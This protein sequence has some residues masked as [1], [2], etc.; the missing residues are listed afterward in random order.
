MPISEMNSNIFFNAQHSPIGA[1]ASFTLGSKGA[2]GGLGLELGKPADQ[3]VF[4]GIADEN[5]IRPT[6]CGWKCHPGKATRL[7]PSSKFASRPPRQ[8]SPPSRFDTPFRS[9]PKIVASL[10]P[11]SE[12]TFILP[13]IITQNTCHE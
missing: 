11:S 2:K 9:E 8:E 1:F 7:Q 6:A 12:N 4:I 3:N 13:L 10:Q 5:S